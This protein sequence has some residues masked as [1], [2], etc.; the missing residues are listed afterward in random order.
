[1]N[2]V[3]LAGNRPGARHLVGVLSTHLRREAFETVAD[4]RD[5]QFREVAS[6]WLAGSHEN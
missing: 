2:A 1:M 3:K 6:E 5:H 4:L